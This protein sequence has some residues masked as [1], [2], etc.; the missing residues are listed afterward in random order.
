VPISSGE[1][2][3]KN[4]TPATQLA[5]PEERP[6]DK[7]GKPLSESQLAWKS[8]REFAETASMAE[9]NKRRA[10]D[11]AFADFVRKNLEREFEGVGDAAVAVGTMAVR[12]D[13]TR[14]TQELRQFAEAYR[15]ASMAE[16]KRLSSAAMNPNGYE[17]Y[18]K[19]LDAC[20]A[21]GLL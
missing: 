4:F 21:A 1:I 3:H 14:I 18:Q 16:V 19:N 20:I 6:L 10:S 9:I 13:N 11:R 17:Q 12:Q 7:N 5:E 8:M 2:K 15:R